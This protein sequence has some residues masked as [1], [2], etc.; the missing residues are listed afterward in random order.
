MNLLKFH[1]PMLENIHENVMIFH[2]NFMN[3]LSSSDCILHIDICSTLHQK[4]H[5]VSVTPP[6]C[7]VKRSVLRLYNIT[8]SLQCLYK[9]IIITAHYCI[10]CYIQHYYGDIIILKCPYVNTTVVRKLSKYHMITKGF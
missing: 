3:L 1:G 7:P 8:T 9:H 10:I 5:C 6:G 4:G 2:A